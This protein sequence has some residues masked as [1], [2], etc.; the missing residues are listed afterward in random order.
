MEMSEESV[1]AAREGVTFAGLLGIG[2]AYMGLP[3]G[4]TSLQA[5]ATQMPKDWPLVL[6]RLNGWPLLSR[7]SND[8]L[9]LLKS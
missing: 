4:P 6:K 2:L 8:W 3:V 1:R 9:S 7:R 5:W